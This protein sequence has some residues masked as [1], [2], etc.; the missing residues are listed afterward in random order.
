M[1]CETITVGESAGLTLYLWDNSAE[2]YDG[3]LRPMVLLCPGGAYRMTSDREG[4]GMA[5]KF[6]AMGC[7]AAV[8]R[9]SVAPARFP[10]ALL[11]LAMAVTLIRD[12]A[13]EWYVDPKRIVV[14]GSSAGGHLAAC[15]GA[16]W[17]EEWLTRLLGRA[18]EDRRPN[19]LILSY[20]VVTA[21]PLRNDESFRNLL[22]EAYEARRAEFSLEH[23]ITSSFP[24]TFLWH[25][26]EDTSVPPENSL[27]LALALRKAGVSV[28]LHL[29]AVGQHGLGTA[30]PLTVS[31][32]GRGLQPRCAGWMALAEEWLAD[33]WR[34]PES[35]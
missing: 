29:Y 4:E 5:L 6:V 2:L 28:E 23:R 1:R 20:P 16:F 15:L 8:L 18:A 24:P 35:M 12:R 17:Q 14:Q 25:G 11:E 26:G 27:L 34:R 7:H 3:R 21:G 22:G 32:D 33:L 30:G 9:Y 13:A 31:A 19:A 10:A